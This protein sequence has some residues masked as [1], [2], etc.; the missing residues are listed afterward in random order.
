MTSSAINVAIFGASGMV[1]GGVLLECLDGDGVASVLAVTRSPLGTTHPKLRETRHP[2]FFNYDALRGEFARVDA[3]FFCL[4]VSSLGMSE[5]EYTRLTY[6][7][8]LAAA[9]TMAEANPRMVFC[10]VSGRGTDTHGRQMW[11][12]VKGRTEDA[13][14]ALPFGG[15]YMFRPGFIYAERGVRPRA[16]V[17]RALYPVA[18]PIFPVLRRLFPDAITTTSRIGRAMIRVASTGGDRRVL[19]PR[20]INALGA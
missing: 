14:L 11:A 17:Y 7:L 10:Y 2:D 3:C 20:D 1:G 15:A 6:D 13:I 4:G 19:D 12:R 16:R 5:A 8:T 18:A 9:R